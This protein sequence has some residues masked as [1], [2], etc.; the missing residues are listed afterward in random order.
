MD[1]DLRKLRYFVAVA[2]TLHFGRA[3]ESL[4]I[5][6]PVLSR[7][8]R[9]LEDELKAELFVRDRRTTELTPA[10]RQLLTGARPLLAG[11][12]A[13]QRR[14]A[15]TASGDDRLVVGFMPGLTVTGAN[16]VLARRHPELTIEVRRMEWATQTSAILDGQ[17]DLGY[18]RMPMQ[19][20][21]LHTVTVAEEPCEV[22]LPAAHRLAD[23]DA[24]ELS[25]LSTELLLQPAPMIPGWTGESAAEDDHPR[26]TITTVE[27]KLEHVAAGVGVVVLP[28]SAAGY[29]TRLDVA[30]VR[31]SD[32]AP[33]RIVLAWDRSRH[34]P[35]IDEY[36][37]IAQSLG[38]AAVDARPE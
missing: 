16:R 28:R 24:L 8:I 29:Y 15:R 34:D 25:D 38:L 26:P 19:T 6:Q 13:L 30:H 2:E 5:A 23:K 11:A 21:G 36:A 17:I 31:I 37:E 3:A 35:L 7:Q 27:E 20:D 22:L 12:S 14:V 1:L 4:H 10:G 32:L 9:A 33:V 18:L